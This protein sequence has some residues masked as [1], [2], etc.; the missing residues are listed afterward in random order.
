ML[1]DF[2]QPARHVALL[3]PERCRQTQLLA[4]LAQVVGDDLGGAIRVRRD[5]CD[6]V[7]LVALRV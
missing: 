6:V 3:L 4:R 1:G 7:Q 5:G 2:S